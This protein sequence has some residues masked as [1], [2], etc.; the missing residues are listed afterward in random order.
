MRD[1]GG[2][3]QQGL[4]LLEQSLEQ[5]RE[6]VRSHQLSAGMLSNQ[7]ARLSALTDARLA[8]MASQLAV[9]GER[10]GAIEELLAKPSETR[11]TEMRSRGLLALRHDWLDDATRDL[12]AAVAENPYDDLAWFALGHAYAREEDWAEAATAMSRAAKYASARSIERVALASL[13]G[14]SYLDLANDSD[15]A[16]D[17]VRRGVEQVDNCPELLMALSRRSG[18]VAPLRAAL[19]LEPGRVLE[20]VAAGLRGVEE[21]CD[22]AI[23][24]LEDDVRRFANCQLH[25]QPH[26]RYLVE[27][28]ELVPR[29]PER[30]GRATSY[31]AALVADQAQRGASV[32][33][34]YQHAGQF[35][36]VPHAAPT[37]PGPAP[38][39][40]LPLRRVDEP[41]WWMSEQRWDT[42]VAERAA[43]RK[44]GQA[45]LTYPEELRQWRERYRAWEV[46]IVVQQRREAARA[47]R[48]EVYE[49]RFGKPADPSKPRPKRDSFLVP[50][51]RPGRDG[52]LR[53][54]VPR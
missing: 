12:R 6:A 27:Q 33:R 13:L 23:A 15:A 48:K 43:Q 30:T 36:H 44:A 19:R 2:Y 20:A 32:D 34:H 26:L 49:Y 54:A 21:A 3:D 52:A 7:L 11:A 17:L 46:A 5:G 10:L 16:L 8:A 47:L 31:L 28:P 53:V 4:A 14:A 25:Y 29:P 45:W 24:M 9:V 50:Y 37:N 22:V 39:E 40:P 1:L 41:K 35:L 42:L 38:V 51:L 18:D